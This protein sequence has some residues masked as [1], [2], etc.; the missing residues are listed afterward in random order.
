MS[1]YVIWIDMDLAKIYHLSMPRSDSPTLMHR[2]EIMHHTSRDPANHKNCDKFFA[3]IAAA[4]R[5][6]SEVLVTGPGL[7]KEHFK[8]YLERHDP[9]GLARKIVGLRTLDRLSDNRLLEQSREFFRLYDL[10]G[11]SMPA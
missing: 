11:S 1:A 3:E 2:H 4:I 10:Y 6:G 8:A 7:A 5:E 9:E